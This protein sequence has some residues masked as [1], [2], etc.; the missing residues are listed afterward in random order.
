MK[1]CLNVVALIIA[2]FLLSCAG[3]GKLRGKRYDCSEK[4]N[5]AVSLYKAQ[6]YSRAA[7]I[8]ENA[9]IQCNGSSS[10]DSIM[11]YLGMAD[12]HVKKFIDAR[13]EFEKVVQDFPNSPFSAE[14]Q[15]RIGL[16]VFRQ[17]HQYS[18][19]QS[20]TKEAIR[21]FRDFLDYNKDGP[22]VDSATHYLNEA[23]EKLAHKEFS[24]ARF[25]EKVN[26]PE[27][28]VVYYKTFISQYPESQF[29]SQAYL[30]TAG[31]LIKLDRKS[32][33]QDLLNDLIESGK[34]PEITSKA[35]LLLSRT[36]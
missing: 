9:K 5:Q 35:K 17:S 11:Y 8:L 14:S 30:N 31:L 28:A 29:T 16:S 26:E 4:V 27:A 33:A 34:W 21:L 24:N 10:M 13:M 20:E 22:F 2:V 18:R 19:D 36:K 6:K 12:L 15:F 23:E 32:E 25:Y 3:N 7:V 1:R